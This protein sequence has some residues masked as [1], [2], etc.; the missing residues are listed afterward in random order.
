MVNPASNP[1]HHFSQRLKAI[2]STSYRRSLLV[3]I[4]NLRN[5]ALWPSLSRRFQQLN[6]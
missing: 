5:S 4:Q 2:A 3:L 1:L 6:I